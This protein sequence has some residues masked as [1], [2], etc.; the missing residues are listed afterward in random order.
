MRTSVKSLLKMTRI[1]NHSINFGLTIEH[2]SDDD[3]SG[4]EIDFL[5]F[6]RKCP[7]PLNPLIYREFGEGKKF[8]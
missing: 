4:E 5:C 1:E 7:N 2:A 8:F 3:N 6:Q